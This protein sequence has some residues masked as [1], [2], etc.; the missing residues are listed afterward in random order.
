MNILILFVLFTAQID[1][2]YSPGCEE[3]AI[4]KDSILPILRA[5]NITIKYYNIETDSGY[6]HLLEIEKKYGSYVDKFPAMLI[7]DKLLVGIDE[8]RRINKFIEH[9]DTPVIENSF[10]IPETNPTNPI[11]FPIPV[12][13]ILINFKIAYFYTPGCK[14]CSRCE[15]ILS[16]LEHDFPNIEITRFNIADRNNMV[17]FDNLCKEYKVVE[18]LHLVTPAIF[19]GDTS[20][21]KEIRDEDIYHFIHTSKPSRYQWEKFKPVEHPA[22]AVTENGIIKRFV[23][24]SPIGIIGAGLLDGI[25]PCAFA[26]IIF[27]ISY[28]TFAAYRRREIL[29]VGMSFAIAVFIAYFCI[30][31]GIFKFVSMIKVFPILSEIVYYAI[32]GLTFVLGLVS[33]YDYRLYKKGRTAEMKLQ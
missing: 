32:A 23:G 27:F 15:H 6:K 12:A 17:L 18:N 26:T 30:G 5:K 28:L 10:S 14:E 31:V 29:L 1:Y 33:L 8:I 16:N 21:I 19:I 20:F 3:C 24:L 2:F 11:R 25:N 7:G 9:P 22:M 4:I 13:S